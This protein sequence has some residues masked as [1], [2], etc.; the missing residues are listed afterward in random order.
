M[1]N[2]L[3][4]ALNKPKT[5]TQT[6]APPSTKVLSSFT[7]Q[8]LSMT[9]FAPRNEKEAQYLGLFPYEDGST[10]LRLTFSHGQMIN[11]ESVNTY[12][13]LV[14]FGT[15]AEHLAHQLIESGKNYMHIRVHGRLRVEEN[16]KDGKRYINNV[17]VAYGYS[18][19]TGRFYTTR[20]GE[21]VIGNR[22]TV[23]TD[24]Q[25]DQLSQLESKAKRG[26]KK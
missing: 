25:I 11:G 18:D 4:T 22:A 19:T 13:Q 8:D 3:Y 15:L 7:V 6:P 24:E 20:N 17:I 12:G 21:L 1:S 14:M 16:T 5:E 9:V 26:S 10:Y 23:L 2:L